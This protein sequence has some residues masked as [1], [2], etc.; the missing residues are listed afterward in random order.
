MYTVASWSFSLRHPHHTG[1][2]WLK[3][4]FNDISNF[5]SSQ[6]CLLCVSNHHDPPQEL[7]LGRTEKFQ[8]SGGF[9]FLCWTLY[10]LV[11]INFQCIDLPNE[12]TD[13]HKEQRSGIPLFWIIKSVT[14][15]M[16]PCCYCLKFVVRL[17]IRTCGS[18]RF[19][20][21]RHNQQIQHSKKQL[22][23][24]LFKIWFL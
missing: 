6:T 17:M 23:H 3:H 14:H 7:V 9:T 24:S 5:L 11:Y 12:A 10:K 15:Y 8:R 4:V 13:E 18:Q 20:L 21:Y 22:F 19:I 16:Q 2:Y 1:S